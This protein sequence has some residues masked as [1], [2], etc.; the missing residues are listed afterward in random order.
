MPTPTNRQEL[1]T[2]LGQ[3]G[4]NVVAQ[5]AERRRAA[6]AARR[7]PTRR[8]SSIVNLDPDAARERSSRSR[9]SPRSSRNVS[10]FV[11]SQVLDA[12]PADGGDAPGRARSSSRCR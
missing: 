2:F 1:A 7:G 9:R 11:M 12:E 4:V 10:F 6:G 8:S 5:L 3:F